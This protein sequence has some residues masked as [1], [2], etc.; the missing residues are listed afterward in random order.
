MTGSRYLKRQLLVGVC[1]LA[2][3]ATAAAQSRNFDIAAGNLKNAL[4]VY[5]RQSGVQLIYD[6]DAIQGKRSAGVHGALSPEDALQALLAGT[7]LEVQ[8]DSSGA[9]AIRA[10]ARPKRPD[11]TKKGDSGALQ[12]VL[13]TAQ[14]RSENLEK[15]PIAVSTFTQDEL[16]A[17]GIN[18]ITALASA[19]PSLQIQTNEFANGAMITLR[20]ISAN[21]VFENS[22]PSVGTY[23]DG[24]Y[25]PRSQGLLAD[26]YDLE[27]V[28]ILPGPQGTLYGRNTIAGAVN[29]ISASPTPYYEGAADISYGNYSDVL[30]HFMLNVPVTDSLALRGAFSIHENSG[31]FDTQ[32]STNQNYDKADD[33]SARLTALWKPISELSWRLSYD[34]YLSH[35]TPTLGIDTGPN[36]QP[37]DGQ[38]VFTRAVNS[39]VEPSNYI[40][41]RS[42]RSRMDWQISNGLSLAYLA[43]YQSVID[44][45]KQNSNGTLAGLMDSINN[46]QNTNINQ[47][48][49]LQYNEGS[50]KAIAGFT[51]FHERTINTSQ[52]ILQGLD[53]GLN[54]GVPN[55]TADSVGEFAQVTYS[56]TDSL[57]LT[58]GARYSSDRYGEPDKFSAECPDFTPQPSPYSVPA[59]CFS[60][61]RL[62]SSGRSAAPTWKVSADFD[63]DAD[64]L[65]YVT[66][67]TGYLAGGDN[68]TTVP[69]FRNYQPEF[70]TNYEVGTKSQLLG[71]ALILNTAVYYEDFRD[72][73]ES[74]DTIGGVVTE[75][76][77]RATIY[78]IEIDPKWNFTMSDH[79]SGFATYIH[80]TF[81]QYNN[82]IDQQTGIIYPSL[83]G[84][85]LPNAPRFSARLQYAHDFAMPNGAVL[86][87][88]AE[89]YYQTVDYLREFNLPI[90]EVPAYTKTDL[91]LAYL[92]PNGSWSAQAY[93]YNL[94]DAAVRNGAFPTIGRYFSYYN[95]P[96]TYGVRVSAKF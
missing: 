64:N 45:T 86:T 75:N 38:P 83:A 52:Y 61:T 30:A 28:E 47:E 20:G 95:P 67:S 62:N 2:L 1:L 14:K 19:A 7:G 89:I 70:V 51:Y 56:V 71:R 21:G 12:E 82:A 88:R 96:R 66:I 63:I 87:P 40:D 35:G 18:Q 55:T 25:V 16:T 44:D 65:G 9:V 90:D 48:L 26:L 3:A 53:I 84:K 72:L 81:D 68:D 36:G 43:G 22:S 91:A 39:V 34:Q 23:I 37:T 58:A 85:T 77:G 93:A 42:I 31:Y 6:S 80:A 15:T 27:R 69:A 41:N 57:R 92:A 74:H 24:I 60:V 46:N 78:G 32:G 4:D 50:L 5:A 73:Q 13:V 11:T 94:E 8:R 10:V 49:D 17:S 29:I 33:F 59:S 79:L 76:A 54:F